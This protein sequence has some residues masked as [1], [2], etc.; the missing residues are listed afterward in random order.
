MP[1]RRDRLGHEVARPR[2]GAAGPFFVDRGRGRAHAGRGRGGRRWCGG[3][4]FLH[5]FRRGKW[6]SIRAWHSP[7]TRFDNAERSNPMNEEAVRQALQGAPGSELARRRE[8]LDAILAAFRTGGPEAATT[9]LK[10]SM[11]GLKTELDGRIEALKK[12]L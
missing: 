10:Q 9:L 12:K 5:S 1:R 6:P 3:G 2:D 11:S 8:L 7:I 4:E